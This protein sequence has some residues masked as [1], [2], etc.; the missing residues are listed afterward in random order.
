MEAPRV[1]VEQCFNGGTRR[2]IA[3]LMAED[4]HMGED[5]YSSTYR[6]TPHERNRPTDR[7]GR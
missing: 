6:R 3:E 7:I 1:A 2:L 5:K 4:S